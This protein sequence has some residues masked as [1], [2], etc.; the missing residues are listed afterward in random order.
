[1]PNQHSRL[2]PLLK[3][4]GL[5]GTLVINVSLARPAFAA[6]LTDWFFD[7]DNN[8]LQFT[9]PPGTIPSY[10]VER[11]PARLVVYIPDTEVSV[12]VTELYPAGL[13]RR[14]SLSQ[15]Q[16]TQ[17]KV[18][19]DFAPEVAISSKQVKLEQ[20]RPQANSWQLRLLVD[21]VEIDEA[22][23][24]EVVEEPVMLDEEV[25]TTEVENSEP[26]ADNQNS[27]TSQQQDLGFL[28]TDPETESPLP[29]P[30]PSADPSVPLLVIPTDKSDSVRS[31]LIDSLGNKQSANQPSEIDDSLKLQ[32]R[33]SEEN[34][35]PPPPEPEVIEQEDSTT[36][37]IDVIPFGEPL[38]GSSG[39]RQ[40]KV[41][42]DDS[43]ILIE[44]GE[45]IGL[46]YPT[47][48][49]RLPR[50][51]EQQE[52]LLLEEAIA[53]SSGRI[54]VPAKTP[55]IGSF[56]TN[57]HGSIFTVRSIYIDGRFIPFAAESELLRGHPHVNGKVLAGS[58]VGGG[59]A[60]LLLTGS[61]LGFLAGA[62]VGAGTVVLTSPRSVTIEAEH[63]V[64][65][66]VVEDLPRS[67]FYDISRF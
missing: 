64:E 8:Q 34:F 66:R 38:P 52:V 44:E 42:E 15:E 43:S 21:E 37:S 39:E 46:V 47:S 7:P 48:E 1:M 40:S 24:S 59:L 41:L 12:D 60:L 5:V 10:S 57:R 51:I 23:I 25:E 19:I 16:P 18:I 26:A 36:E 55:V 22:E 2:R 13:V 14:V 65:V 4:I 3:F 54:I 27:T 29:N 28:E 63:I 17:A 30:P 9:I 67:R 33:T 35:V 61:G 58:S 6:F 56:D 49:L 53:D 32:A 45:V 20:V 31:P 50:D 11:K 62:A